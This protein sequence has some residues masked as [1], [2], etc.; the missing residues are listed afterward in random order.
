M[1]SCFC[2]VHAAH[3]RKD[4]KSG[5]S[6]QKRAESA[7]KAV[8]RSVTTVPA[9]RGRRGRPRVK[10]AG[11]SMK[12]ALSGTSAFLAAI[13]GA[14]PAFADTQ[15]GGIETI[16]VTAEK[17]A[18]SAQTVGI[19]LTTPSSDDLV[20]RGIDKVNQ[21]EYATPS[22]EVVPAFGSGQPEFRLRGVGFD[23]YASN[24]SSTVGVYVDEV[25]YPVP[26]QTQGLLFDLSRTE[27]L[28]GPQGTLYGVNTTGGAINFITNRPTDVFTAGV[29]GDYDSHGEFIGNGYVSG[30][31]TDGL[32][33]RFA[34]ITDQ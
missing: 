25:A 27:V 1:L 29:T 6:R 28:Y 5:S 32:D 26:A 16:T 8:A 19:A 4:Q 23:D 17:R 20:K 11:D 22:L 13:F 12:K 33:G 24:N 30:P 9:D 7:K 31:I 2:A 14:V 34:F 18:E 21:L 10:C 15:T 3:V